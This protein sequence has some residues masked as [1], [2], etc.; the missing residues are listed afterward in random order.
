MCLA[1]QRRAILRHLNFNKWSEHAV[2]C[3]FWLWNVLLATA[4]CHFSTSELRKVVQDPQFFNILSCKCASRHS[5]MPFFDIS[6][7]KSELRPL[8]FSMLTCKC[9][10]RHSGVPFFLSALSSYLYTRRFS[11]PTFS[12]SRPTNHCKNTAIRDLPNIRAGW[13]SVFWLSRSCTFFLLTLLLFSAFHL[14]TLLL[15]SAFSTVHI[16]GS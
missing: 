11:E 10:S 14:L 7:S 2:F 13:S 8:V 9:A 1:P 6:T 15:C 16:V 4:A 12:P 3:T 5:G